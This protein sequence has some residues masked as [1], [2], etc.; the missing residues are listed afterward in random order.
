MWDDAVSNGTLYSGFA[1]TDGSENWSSGTTTA[2]DAGSYVETFSV[3][4]VQAAPLSFFV[5]A[6]PPTET[7][8]NTSNPPASPNLVIGDGFQ[9]TIAAGTFAANQ[10][11]TIVNGG[12]TYN[13]GSTDQNGTLVLNGTAANVGT[14][15]E[16]Y[17]VGGIVATPAL[18]FT[19][20]GSGGGLLP[21]VLITPPSKISTPPPASS[22]CPSIAG[23][24]NENSVP[25]ATW[26]LDTAGGGSVVIANFQGC[27]GSSYTA[28]YTSLG[29]NMFSV[30]ASNPVPSTAPWGCPQPISGLQ[31]KVTLAGSCTTGSAS[32]TAPGGPFSTMWT[33]PLPAGQVLTSVSFS[34]GSKTIYTGQNFVECDGTLHSGNYFGYRY[35]VTYTAVDQDGHAMKNT[36]TLTASESVTKVS[37]NYTPQP[38]VA[39]SPL[40]LNNAAQILDM[41]ATVQQDKAISAGL[42]GVF[43]QTLTVSDSSSGVSLTRI[44]CLVYSTTDVTV[45]DVTKAQ[46]KTC[47]NF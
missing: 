6:A 5:I 1:T 32:V 16:A 37:A 2:R 11:V 27:Q 10:P 9:Q 42:K 7:M 13:L 25:A 30:T 3:A 40:G 43:K 33:D 47:T 35:C 15:T 36:A 31:E 8:Q 23:T 17:I 34:M 12:T 4:G 38:N 44:N 18:N 28:A 26:A 21:D 24:W 46:N 14:Y 41:L 19:V 39:D 20:S 22:S 45:N 29:N